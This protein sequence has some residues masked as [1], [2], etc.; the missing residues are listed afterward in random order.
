MRYS[1]Q[2]KLWLVSLAD[3]DGFM[4]LFNDAYMAVGRA[5]CTLGKQ[6]P[7]PYHTKPS[8][9]AEKVQHQMQKYGDAK[10]LDV[11]A[12]LDEAAQQRLVTTQEQLVDVNA[13]GWLH[14]KK[15]A[16]RII[17]PK[18]KFERLD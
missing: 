10:V 12:A 1:G 9:K 7:P 8:A 17:A 14:I 5:I 11:E 16:P 3:P 4:G 18:P 15:L 6:E 2:H 13:P